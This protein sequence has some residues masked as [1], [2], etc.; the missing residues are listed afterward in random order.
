[1]EFYCKPCLKPHPI[2]F[3]VLE[4]KDKLGYDF[5]M[6]DIITSESV[7]LVCKLCGVPTKFKVFEE[8][9]KGKAKTKKGK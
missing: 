2:S 8:M 1:M 5:I 9:L 6:E 7:N 3:I 4:C